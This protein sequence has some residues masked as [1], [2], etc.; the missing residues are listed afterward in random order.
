MS[1][2]ATADGEA[3]ANPRVV[4]AYDETS[5]GDR[6]KNCREF[7]TAWPI[8]DRRQAIPCGGGWLRY[9]DQEEDANYYHNP[10]TGTTSWVEPK[11][12]QSAAE[13]SASQESPVQDGAC[14]LPENRIAPPPEDAASQGGYSYHDGY[15]WDTYARLYGYPSGYHAYYD[16]YWGRGN[17]AHQSG[18]T[19]MQGT[20]QPGNDSA[21]MA[22]PRAGGIIY[23]PTAQA[24]AAAEVNLDALSRLDKILAMAPGAKVFFYNPCRASCSRCASPPPSCLPCDA[25]RW[26]T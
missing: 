4:A 14:P 7:L 6:E 25:L 2:A 23:E 16:Y 10:E 22:M 11:E 17:T 20:A 26:S 12:P 9:W 21:N 13:G 15:E 3:D 5:A 19:C 24:H 8:V 18:T 1:T